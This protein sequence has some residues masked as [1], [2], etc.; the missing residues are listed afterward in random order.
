MGGRLF[1]TVRCSRAVSVVDD[2]EGLADG[3][4]GVEGGPSWM[5]ETL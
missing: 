3:E 4:A 5:M 2:V 1:S